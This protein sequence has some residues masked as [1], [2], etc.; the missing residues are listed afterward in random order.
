MAKVTSKEH[1]VK[2]GKKR[3]TLK[4]AGCLCDFCY[5]H[6]ND[7]RQELNQQF[8]EIEFNRDLFRQTLNEQ[9]NNS[10]FKQIDQWEKDSIEIIKQIANQCRQILIEHR[11]DNINQIEINLAKLTDQ[12]KY[13]RQENNF[14]EIDLNQYKDKL[15]Q[16]TIELNRLHNVSIQQNSTSLVN[17]ISVVVSYGKDMN[18][19]AFH[20][21]N[22]YRENNF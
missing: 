7:H 1:C 17:K 4:C 16:L 9:T 20:R 5:D 15:K 22:F 11:N 14:N 18:I 2:C 21:K 8:D 6:L 3:A 12:L 10:L 13:T 19:Y